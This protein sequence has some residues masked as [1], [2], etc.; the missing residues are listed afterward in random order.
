M[1]LFHN[2][3]SQE[4]LK[5]VYRSL[6]VSVHHVYLMQAPSMAQ[7]VQGRFGYQ[8]VQL[9][10]TNPLGTGSYGA[11]Y[12]AMCDGVSCAGKILHPT[13]FQ[14]N[15]PGA[16]TI[17]RRF[18]QECSFLSSIRHPNIVQYLGSYRDPETLLP[19]LLMELMDESLTQFLERLQE[20]LP[21]H[22]QVDLCHDIALALTYLH[23]NNII[24]RDLSSNNVL[25]TGHRVKV[26]DFGMAKL[27]DANHTMM[28]MP[29]TPLTMCPGTLAYMSP[30]ALDDP[31]VYTK[32]LDCFSFGVLA[33]QII[34]RQF[35]G[36]GP[37]IKKIQDPRYPMGRLQILVPEIERRKSHIDRI[38]PTH[39][40]LP[41]ATACL[42]YSEEDRPSTQELCRR[43]AAL[44]EGLQYSGSV[45]RAQ[46]TNTPAPSATAD[47]EGGE[48]LIRELQ[49][50][51]EEPQQWQEECDQRTGDLQQQLQVSDDDDDEIEEPVLLQLETQDEHQ[52]QGR[53]DPNLE[54]ILQELSTL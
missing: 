20:P 35:P 28:M 16:V 5:V 39:P 42:S 25:L 32:K 6:E 53:I 7:Q 8:T 47:R 46:E 31:P 44:K 23:S 51:K 11:V 13:F 36:P 14:F 43:L 41:I 29:L 48:R 50:E 19:V 37:R 22:I 15:D 1:Q 27:F 45:R 10:K 24:H 52:D 2:C 38:D 9:I 4:Q 17:M 40:L 33:I 26:T 21:Y 49:Q 34:T 18:E 12:K 54:Q 3:I 30:E